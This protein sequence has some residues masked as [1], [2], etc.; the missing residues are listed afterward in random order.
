MVGVGVTQST[1]RDG[2]IGKT[3]R[4]NTAVRPAAAPVSR[5]AE[6]MFLAL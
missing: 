5:R 3:F 4:R 2:I 1:G 6:T